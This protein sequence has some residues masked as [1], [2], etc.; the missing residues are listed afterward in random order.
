M[1]AY[2]LDEHWERLKL[3]RE[4]AGR[5]PTWLERTFYKFA[6]AFLRWR[7]GR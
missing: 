7:C 2:S 5:Q 4:C 3:E 1:N 6:L